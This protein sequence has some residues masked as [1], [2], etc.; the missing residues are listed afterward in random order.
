MG[1]TTYLEIVDPEG[2]HLS[3]GEEGDILVTNLHNYTMPLI[4]Y[5]IGDLGIMQQGACPCGRPH[6][7]LKAVTGRS[8]AS[9]RLADGT[10]ISPTFFIHFI[11]VVH[12][13]GGIAR[14]QIAQRAYDRIV[15]RL[16][17][18]A[19]FDLAKWP[20]RERLVKDIRKVM[21][22]PCRVDFE[23]VADIPKTPTGKHLYT[24]REMMDEA[25]G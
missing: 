15:V 13:D 23:I 5:R 1:E 18:K 6:P 2:R 21:G 4:R 7:L 17:P 8:G 20:K 11:G 22:D 16:V 25:T 14:F 19:G 10:M 24:V 9:F 3:P 12:N